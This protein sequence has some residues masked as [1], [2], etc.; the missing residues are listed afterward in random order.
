VDPVAE[1][2]IHG[3]VQGSS[4]GSSRSLSPTRTGIDRRTGR[5]VA[6]AP[7]GRDVRAVRASIASGDLPP[8]P[9]AK[10]IRLHLSISPAY[11]RA[12][13]DAVRGERGN[14]PEVPDLD[15][16]SQV[17]DHAARTSTPSGQPYR[18][19]QRHDEQDSDQHRTRRHIH[20]SE[21]GRSDQQSVRQEHQESA[22]RGSQYAAAKLSR[23]AMENDQESHTYA[24][25]L[26]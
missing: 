26:P 15:P 24:T 25:P 2:P 8:E 4:G 11:A 9:T 5:R 17:D 6:L 14:Q 10:D 22:A 3:S 18:A 16:P 21:A 7:R 19:T 20:I 23:K 1:D 12:T 13:R